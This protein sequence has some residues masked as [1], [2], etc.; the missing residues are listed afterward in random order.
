[1]LPRLRRLSLGILTL[2]AVCSLAAAP[3]RV[4]V[5][6]DDKAAEAALSAP[7][8]AAGAKVSV[9]APTSRALAEVDTVLLYSRNFKSLPDA[10]RR[11]LAE[12]ARHGGGLVAVH[13]GVAAGDAEWG[14]AVLGGAWTDESRKFRNNMLLTIRTD[15]HPITAEASTFDIEEDTIYDLAL[16]ENILV[17]SSAFTPKVVNSRKKNVK[18]QEGRASVYDIQPQSW[19]YEAADHRAVVVLPG[20]EISTLSHATIR[21]FVARGLAWT[22]KHADTNELV[23]KSDLGSLRYPVGGPRRGA[24]A[25]A[26]FK[27]QPGFKASVL[28]AEPLINKPIAQQWD[29]K[30]RLWVAE[31]PEYP[32]GRRPLTAEAWKEGGVLLPGNYDRPAHD[33]ISVLISSKND[34]VFDQKQVFHEGLELIIG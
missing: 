6:A 17:L 13:G 3:L 16:N 2:C 12:F 24:D 9:G 14:K 30:G 23:A 28:A 11:S 29:E 10:D 4:L 34:G 7:L 18:E 22:A 25:I 19:A 32:N 26:Q 8:A 1:M 5:V 27:L 33:K 21:A 31:T 20:A 15:A